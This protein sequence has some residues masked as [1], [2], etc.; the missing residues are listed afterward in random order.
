M[1]PLQ[2][3]IKARRP[4]LPVASG[5]WLSSLRDARCGVA[6]RKEKGTATS[7]MRSHEDANYASRYVNEL[8]RLAR[9]TDR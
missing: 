6:R 9:G 2:S 4:A 5:K 1:R 8:A 3:Q 7:G